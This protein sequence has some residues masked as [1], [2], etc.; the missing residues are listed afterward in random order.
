MLHRAM[1]Q[2]N[3]RMLLKEMLQAVGQGLTRAPGNLTG[4]LS[5]QGRNYDD[6]R[7]LMVYGRA[8]NGWDDGLSHDCISDDKEL[9]AY[10]LKLL[11]GTN[12]MEECPLHW[13]SE[14]SEAYN[15]NR[16][17][18]LRV[19]KRIAG[20]ACPGRNPWHSEISWSN[21]YKVAP[22]RGGN[23]GGRLQK[24]QFP[25][26]MKLLRLELKNH[27][28]QLVLFVTGMNWVERFLDGLGVEG[29]EMKNEFVKYV[30]KLEVVS[31]SPIPFIV[32][33]RPECRPEDQW[34][35]AVINAFPEK[36]LG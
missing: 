30:G 13:A 31:G 5:I 21:L 7:S 1:A 22:A 2:E 19:S 36:D 14:P 20:H 15:P 10:T 4:S 26:C 6:S 8:V 3:E 18:F 11:A 9:E 23:P 34:V 27:R 32:T 24:L 17:A 25:I 35:E 28:P 12:K 33:V 16:S 29:A